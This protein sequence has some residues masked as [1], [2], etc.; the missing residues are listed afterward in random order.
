MVAS[1]FECT[2][3]NDVLWTKFHPRRSPAREDSTT[4]IRKLQNQKC[5]GR[6]ARF[7]TGVQ[8]ARP[9]KFD[10][11]LCSLSNSNAPRCIIFA[12]LNY[13]DKCHEPGARSLALASWSS[14]SN[15]SH[16]GSFLAPLADG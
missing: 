3:I 6:Y 4:C 1:S 5:K 7:T 13:Q 16:I 14:Y 15:H 9:R 12:T 10:V 8:P 11:M 2:N